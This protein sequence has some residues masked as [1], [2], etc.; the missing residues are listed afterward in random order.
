M[1]KTAQF[2]AALLVIFSVVSTG[3][4]H[5]QGCETETPTDGNKI[6]GYIQPQ[7]DYYFFGN[8]ASGN[9]IKNSTFMF[10]RARIGIMGSIPYNISY[11]VMAELSP[12][13]GGPQLLD[14][15]VTYSPFGKYLRFSV[16][17]FKSPYSLE[18]NTPCFALHT[19]NRSTV[20]NQM[21]GPFREMGLMVLGSLGKEDLLT[22][23]LALLN[24]TGIN[25]LDNNQ[26]KTLAANI[27]FA[28][29]KWLKIGASYKGGKVGLKQA[30]GDQDS[31]KR[32]G[33]DLSLE[34]G[35]LLIQGEY[36]FGTDKGTI[37]SGGGCGGKAAEIS[38][39]TD[40]VYELAQYKKNGFWALAQYNTPWNLQAVVKYETYNPDGT[41]YEYQG[42]MQN[43]PQNTTTIGINYF[44]ND[45]TR[46]Q[47]NYLY[48]AERKTNNIVHEY[49]NDALLIQVQVKF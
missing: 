26:N 8:D 13:A 20:V 27:R 41:T 38:T 33:I 48:N 6:M 29:V 7:F 30:T 36:L 19:I 15:Y 18:L 16:G 24:G 4:I 35:S 11:Y 37:E 25:A 44:I 43:Y 32:Y 40:A 10:K 17:Q 31:F 2:F 9:P 5:A 49:K 46:I 23:R 47:V 12:V 39:G 34:K 1:K 42:V 22:Y 14:A 28:P 3:R 45:W 21:A